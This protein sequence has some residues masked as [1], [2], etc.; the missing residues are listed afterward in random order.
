MHAEFGN[1]KRLHDDAEIEDGKFGV[2]ILDGSGDSKFQWNSDNP[3]E[4]AAA[5]ANFDILIKKGYQAF[6]SN[7]DGT[8]GPQIK[9]FDGTLERMIMMPRASGGR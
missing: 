2:E 3:D 6:K 4:V 7:K 8:P 9:E 5:R 1:F